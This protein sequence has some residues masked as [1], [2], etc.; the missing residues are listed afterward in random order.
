MRVRLRYTRASGGGT[1]SKTSF[2]VTGSAEID[3]DDPDFWS[4]MLGEEASGQSE[5]PL[6]G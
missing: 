4:K 6:S 1:F 2:A 3:L 5:L